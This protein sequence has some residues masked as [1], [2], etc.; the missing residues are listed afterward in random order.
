MLLTEHHSRSSHLKQAFVS[1]IFISSAALQSKSPAFIVEIFRHG[2]TSYDGGGV[3]GL[4]C[5]PA[6]DVG[7]RSSGAP[8]NG[9]MSDGRDGG[10]DRGVL[11]LDQKALGGRKGTGDPQVSDRREACRVQKED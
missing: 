2:C 7:R 8:L 3:E 5:R 1:I 4:H 6:A 10:R 11:P 9:Q